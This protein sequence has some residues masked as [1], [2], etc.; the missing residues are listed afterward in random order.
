MKN[1]FPGYRKKTE[2]EIKTLWTKGTICFDANVLLNLYRYSNDTK[3]AIVE[4]IQKF[5]KNI[6][7]P[8]QAALEY[9][10]NRYEVIAAQEKTYKDFIDKIGQIEKDLQSTSKP[11]FLSEKVHL[12]LKKV[13]KDVNKEVDDS[14][15]KYCDFL[16]SDPIYDSLSKIFE[17]KIS[18]PFDSEKLKEIFKEGETRFKAKIPPGY[19]D[20]KNKQGDRKYGDLVLWKQIIEKAKET[21]APIIFI[22]DE[23]KTDWWWKIKDGR[24]MG[25]RQELVE[26]LMVQAKVEFHMYSSERFL[27]YGLNYLEEQVNKKALEE[28]QEMKRIEVDRYR[29]DKEIERRRFRESRNNEIEINEE[30]NH[31]KEKLQQI[32]ERMMEIRQQ[33]HQLEFDV[34]ENPEAHEFSENLRMH[35]RE[36][37]NERKHL[38]HRINM[39]RDKISHPNMGMRSFKDFIKD[40]EKKTKPNNGYI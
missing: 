12:S 32:D 4:L 20:E 36:L 7:L 30:L 10:K 15:Q 18:P 34:E 27:S 9:N 6:W 23:R 28:I 14:I 1:T 35:Q 39:L 2:K 22:T 38:R 33:R 11:P 40:E 16:K 24:N 31:Y 17:N 29:R 8:H 25:P 19:E 5:E 13:F 37:S 26:E 21:K 3:E